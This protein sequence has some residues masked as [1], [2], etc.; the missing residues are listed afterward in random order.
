MMDTAPAWMLQRA[1]MLRSTSSK[2]RIV[3]IALSC[4]TLGYIVL[5]SFGAADAAAYRE[6]INNDSSAAQK[7]SLYGQ[8]ALEHG[9]GQTTS[10]KA[11]G[12]FTNKLADF[13][14]AVS[15]R[16]SDWSSETK[17][18]I[19]YGSAA[20]VSSTRNR[21]GVVSDEVIVPDRDLLGAKTRIGKC[22]M[23]FG[24]A[25]IYERAVKSH[26]LH[27]RIHGYPL[28]VLRHSI[29]DDVWSKPGY[30]L[31]LLLQELAKPPSQRL[32]WIIWV[33]ADTILLNP[34]VPIEVFLPPSP[35]FDDVYM[36]YT[37]DWN[38]L[39]NGVFPV[40]VNQW[41]VDLFTSI[42][43]FRYFR[44]DEKLSFRDQSAMEA[45]LKEDRFASHITEVPQRWFNAY[46][47]EVNETLNPFQ[48][49]RGD[50]LVHFAGVGPRV[51]RMAYW[52]DRVEQH[53]PDW[54]LE[55]QH[56]SYPAETRTFWAEQRV[57]RN[58][59]E[60]SKTIAIDEANKVLDEVNTQLN[61]YQ[62]R[63]TDEQI[64]KVK[65]AEEKVREIL[66]KDK[67]E[68]HTNVLEERVLVL[69]EVI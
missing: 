59:A 25:A 49:R 60:K 20:V 31:H 65:D 11:A 42:V 54:E 6:H 41:A 64:N 32:E 56:T 18:A 1:R 37:R 15:D 38:G 68:I 58:A 23:I 61:E 17:D 19:K 7:G 51:E 40:R 36:L 45:L 14:H 44:P 30:I 12:G 57:E 2:L 13:H 3:I 55:V 27:D 50:F 28:H 21:T 67:K 26:E 24:D 63:L 35:E 46:Q 10:D 48:V 39:N 29:L 47:G 52:L 4:I 69:N 43:S 22:I 9:T 16:I 5:A 66:R 34:H 53:L 8:D 62:S 33:D